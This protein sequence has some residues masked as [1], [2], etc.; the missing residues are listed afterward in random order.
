LRAQYPQYYI[1]KNKIKLTPEI[2]VDSILKEIPEIYNDYP[3]N[4]V[5]GVKI[6]FEDG[7]VHLRKSNTEP[8]I[9]VYSEGNNKKIAE[10]LADKVIRS[11]QDMIKK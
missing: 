7:W 2:N 10:N 5:D 9:R 4:S 8:I 1:S 3:I 6:E 11:V